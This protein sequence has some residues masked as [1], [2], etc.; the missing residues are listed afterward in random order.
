MGSVKCRRCH[1]VLTH[2]TSI[3]R[4]YGSYCYQIL[5]G[6]KPLLQHK[7]KQRRSHDIYF[8]PKKTLNEVYG[9]TIDD[10]IGDLS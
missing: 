9:K 2:K 10:I 1:R 8:K 3:A 5:F 7:P 4:G 6:S